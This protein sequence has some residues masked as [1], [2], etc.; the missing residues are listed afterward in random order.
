MKTVLKF[1]RNI[2][3]ILLITFL[4]IIG[5]VVATGY[6]EYKKV[7]G[8]EP[9][10]EK[11][12]SLRNKSTYVKIQDLPQAFLDAVV[13]VEDHRFYEHKGID[14]FSI[15][16]AIWTNISQKSLLQGGST[17]SQ[18]VAKNIYLSQ[19]RELSRKVSESF[20]AVHLEKNLN[21]EEILELY[22]NTNYYGEGYYGIGEA[23]RGYYNKE[24]RDL[25]L[26]ECTLLAGI[27]NAPSVY[28]PTVNKKLCK[29]RQN[30][31]I[32]TMVE[33]G[34]LDEATANEL[35]NQEI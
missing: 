13:C 14:I 24:P 3:I 11:L 33:N 34:K 30:Q 1:V 21:K 9:L 22:V 15:G 26:F 20:M 28:A 27:P 23:A 12:D 16:R 10:N 29:E 8:D 35:K 25:T 19:K 2:V 18:Q 4:V 32:Y 6:S 5:L 17:I 31:V 7:L